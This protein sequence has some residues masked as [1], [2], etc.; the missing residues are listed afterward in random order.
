MI[1]G[2]VYMF[3]NYI[4]QMKRIIKTKYSKYKTSHV[5]ELWLHQHF[6]QDIVILD[7]RK[8]KILL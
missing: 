2:Y 7:L 1:F 4:T 8:I 3:I 5:S 6:Y